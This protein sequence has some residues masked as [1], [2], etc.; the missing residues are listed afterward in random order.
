MFRGATSIGIGKV[1]SC[2][3]IDHLSQDKVHEART[4]HARFTSASVSVRADDSSSCKTAA[5]QT[6]SKRYSRPARAGRPPAL[7]YEY[8]VNEQAHS[9]LN[10]GQ[11][12]QVRLRRTELPTNPG[13]VRAGKRSTRCCEFLRHPPCTYSQTTTAADLSSTLGPLLVGETLVHRRKQ[14]V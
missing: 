2:R 9:G 6:G 7:P 14:A 10:G 1:C 4:I 3:E 12:Q 13:E 11:E 5:S 8:P